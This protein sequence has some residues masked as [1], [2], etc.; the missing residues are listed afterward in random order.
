MSHTV[1]VHFYIQTSFIDGAT[2]EEAEESHRVFREEFEKVL[3][4]KGWKKLHHGD[5]TIPAIFKIS[6]TN[7]QTDASVRG[8]VDKYVGNAITAAKK[9]LDE[10][11]VTWTGIYIMT[12]IGTE[13]R[14]YYDE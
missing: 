8:F 12:M 3:D 5:R 7:D 2:E 6:F 13:L 11:E 4:G 10:E 1:Y 14:N 9:R